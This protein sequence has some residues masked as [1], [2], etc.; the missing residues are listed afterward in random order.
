M[1]PGV[2]AGN[3]GQ[4]K[5]H[6]P[7]LAAAALFVAALVPAELLLEKRAARAE[8][9]HRMA[10]VSITWVERNHGPSGAEILRTIAE[11]QTP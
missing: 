4:S 6:R 1:R 11:G 7:L 5:N 8:A 9:V 10:T 3:L 2:K